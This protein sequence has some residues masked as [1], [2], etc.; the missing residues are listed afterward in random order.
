MGAFFRLN[1][2]DKDFAF[3]KLGSNDF[4]MLLLNRRKDGLEGDHLDY[5]VG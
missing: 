1:N 3:E 2:F 5:A 4:K